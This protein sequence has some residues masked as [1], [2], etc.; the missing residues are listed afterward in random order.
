MILLLFILL[1]AAGPVSAQAPSA[2]AKLQNVRRHLNSLRT[3]FEKI[4]A[5]PDDPEWIKKKLA[6]MRE[7]DQYVRF[8]WMDNMEGR[9]GLDG[10]QK[11]I[12]NKK[13][14]EMMAELDPQNTAELKKL[15]DA[16]NGRW[17]TISEVGKE[18]ATSAW[19]LVQHADQNPA[20]Q[21]EVLKKM[22]A[23]PPGEVDPKN[24]AYLDDR[25]A[26][27]AGRPQLYG[28]QFHCVDGKPQPQGADAMD[29]PE[30]DRRRA[31]LGLAPVAEYAKNF[32]ANCRAVSEPK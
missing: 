25:V 10:E 1:S 15:L 21:E 4:P 5:N 18:T 20:F 19:L 28:T 30:T 22:N 24:I 31:E 32:E 23:L 26:V 14:G 9:T 11:G 27:K 16:R 29:L 17:F 8:Q 6:Y 2:E 12:F 3:D 13:V 7:V